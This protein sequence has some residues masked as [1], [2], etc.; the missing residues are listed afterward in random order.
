MPPRQTFASS[1]YVAASWAGSR[2]SKR[3]APTFFG[4]FTLHGEA[5]MDG[6]AEVYGLALKPGQ[7]ELSIADY[8][9]RRLRRRPV[10]GDIVEVDG[11]RLTVR[12][13]AAG[14]IATVGLRLMDTE[15]DTRP[16]SLDK[17]IPR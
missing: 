14:V 6:L 10:E 8:M 9:R 15:Q 11:I 12:T 7:A 2:S 5:T 16:S 17:K 1:A 4:S 3:A 13:L